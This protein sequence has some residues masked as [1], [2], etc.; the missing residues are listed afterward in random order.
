MKEVLKKPK[1]K[2][3]SNTNFVHQEFSVI[4]GRLSIQVFNEF[5]VNAVRKIKPLVPAGDAKPQ[6]Q[7]YA[8]WQPWT[9]D[10]LLLSQPGWLKAATACDIDTVCWWLRRSTRA[11]IT[12]HHYYDALPVIN[13]FKSST[14]LLD[15]M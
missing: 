11:A 8:Q 12:G 10:Q 6:T 14:A 9:I 1:S 15:A 2:I 7:R 13:P 4:S 5:H 3:G